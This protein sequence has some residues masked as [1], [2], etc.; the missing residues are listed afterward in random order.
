MGFDSTL[1]LKYYLY[2][3]RIKMGNK[4]TILM[5]KD[6]V[7]DYLTEQL[8]ISSEELKKYET[9]ALL[10]TSLP[11]EILRIREIEAIKLRDRM[12]ELTRHIS[13]I[14]RIFPPNESTTGTGTAGKTGVAKGHKKGTK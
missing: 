8:Q 13:S 14:K 3:K 10:P 6:S 9:D 11:T 5:V 7:I 1:P 12:Y 4:I 2:A